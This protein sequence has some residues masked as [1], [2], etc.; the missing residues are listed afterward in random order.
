VILQE[1]LVI[2]DSFLSRKTDIACLPIVR[3]DNHMQR[4]PYQLATPRF[5]RNSTDK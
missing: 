1:A 2:L 5:D 4:H 3:A